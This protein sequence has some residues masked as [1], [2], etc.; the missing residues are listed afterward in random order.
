MYPEK[1]SLQVGTDADFTL[2]DP[3]REWTLEDRHALH[4]KN[5]VTP[6]EGETFTG[7]VTGTVVRGD[8]VFTEDD[9]VVGEPGFGT[10]V[11]VDAIDN[12][13]G[14]PPE[15]RPPNELHKGV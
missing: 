10:Q 7:K 11:D 12:D 3:G 2:F 13:Y 14:E 8:V 6:F 1:G 15:N 5:T 4:S 9:G